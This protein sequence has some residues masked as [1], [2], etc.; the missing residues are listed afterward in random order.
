[1]IT[2]KGQREIEDTLVS[3]LPSASTYS[4]TAISEDYRARIPKGMI[5]AAAVP[6]RQREFAAGRVAA[7]NALLL[8]GNSGCFPEVGESRQPVWP[9]GFTGS[10]SH[11]NEIAVAVTAPL[12][13]VKGFGIDIESAHL[14][15]KSIRT[16]IMSTLEQDLWSEHSD[17]DE[18][19]TTMMV[20]SYKEAIFKC[21]Y[22]LTGIFLEFLD[23]VVAPPRTLPV[24]RCANADHPASSIVEKVVGSV[25]LCGER[26]LTVC[27][28]A[29]D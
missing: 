24:A 8:A 1:M 25:V 17:H 12:S 4:L 5:S 11:D 14:P 19:T 3:L 6:K 2:T 13:E 21:V 26:V 7:S 18:D 29:N 16:R 27:W 10:I 9:P 28:L 15:D 22:P 20:F 23:V